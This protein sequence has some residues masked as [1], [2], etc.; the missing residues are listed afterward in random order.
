MRYFEL[1]LVFT[2]LILSTLSILLQYQKILYI[3]NNKIVLIQSLFKNR[4]TV[5]Y[6]TENQDLEINASNNRI[7]VIIDYLNG[8]IEER[9]VRGSPMVYSIRYANISNKIAKIIVGTW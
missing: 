6:I 5:Y 3:Y 4:E 7:H 9:G 2:V 8:T 1:L